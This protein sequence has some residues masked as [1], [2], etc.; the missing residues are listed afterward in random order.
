MAGVERVRSILH[1]DAFAS[2]VPVDLAIEEAEMEEQRVRPVLASMLVS[3]KK[4]R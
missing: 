1:I 3:E 2:N 4:D